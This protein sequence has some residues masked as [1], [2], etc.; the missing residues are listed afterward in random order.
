MMIALLTL[1]YASPAVAED[2]AAD[3]L[4]KGMA[5]QKEGRVESAVDHYGT[6]IRKDP[7]MAAC[8]WELG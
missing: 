3:A 5:A 2:T 6:C 8:H 7:K 4:E 1:L